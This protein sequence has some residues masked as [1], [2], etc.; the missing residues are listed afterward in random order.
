MFNTPPIRPNGPQ[1]IDPRAAYEQQSVLADQM[2][3]RSQQYT[4]GGGLE[5]LAMMLNAYGARKMGDRA[6]GSLSAALEQ[7]NERA[8][9]ALLAEQEAE[10]AAR[11][12]EYQDFIRKEQWK[13]DNPE[14]TAFEREALFSGV[15]QGSPEARARFMR[16]GGGPTVNVNTGEQG[17]RV[18]TIPP[19]YELIT[20]PNTGRSRLEAMPGSEAA[21]EIEESQNKT[22]NR[23][24]QEQISSDIVLDEVGIARQILEQNPSLSTGLIGRMGDL[25]D[26]GPGQN[27]ASSLEGLQSKIGLGELNNMRQNSPTGGALGNV[28]EGEREALAAAYG[29]LKQEQPAE[30]LNYRLARFQN[31]HLDVTHGTPAQ[32]AEMVRRGE[33]TE[34]LNQR[35]NSLY[36]PDVESLKPG[37]GPSQQPAQGGNDTMSEFERRAARYRQ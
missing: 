13:R 20:D 33:I 7:E 23:V 5:A 24:S 31:A 9:A 21:R 19:G 30:W 6:Q 8:R 1:V 3:Q 29:S 18:G 34:E 2:L 22:Q 15:E 17:P 26:Y 37:S 25:F 4:G 27:L 36:V 28:T 12:A 32:R 35:I 16:A 14:L 11:E 10:A